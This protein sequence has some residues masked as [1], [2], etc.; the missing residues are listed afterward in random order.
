MTVTAEIVPPRAPPHEVTLNSDGTC[1]QGDAELYPV[2]LWDP[3]APALYKVIFHLADD[4]RTLD[5]VRGYFG[6]RKIG[7]APA[8]DDQNAPAML[9]LNNKPIYLRGALYQSYHCDGVYTAREAAT[10]RH[11]IRFARQM[12][13]D[14]LRIHIKLDDPLVLFFADTEGIL[15]MQDF[16]NFGEGGDTALGRRRFEEMLR[17]GMRRDVNHPSII[18]WC[19]CN[20]TWG[21]GGQTELMKIIGPKPGT[22]AAERALEKMANTSSFQW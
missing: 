5:E 9:C 10:L 3:T 1:A 17:A 7:T 15:L 13:F 12:G 2:T 16:P 19:I 4:E 18:A 8:L 21:F 22:K 14:F 11:D 6:M 20:E